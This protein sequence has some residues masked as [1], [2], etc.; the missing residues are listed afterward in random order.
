MVEQ[1]TPSPDRWLS[2]QWHSFFNA[3]VFFSRL[4]PPPGIRFTDELLNHSSRYFT[5]IGG[6]LGLLLATVVAVGEMLWSVPLAVACMMGVSLLL[7]GAFHEDGLADT[8]DGFGGGFNRAAV[9]GI[10][11]DS[12]LGT[13]GAAALFVT[14]LIRGLSWVALIEHGLPVW[15]ALPFAASWSRFWA[16]STL[17]TL[18]YARTGDDTKCKPLATRFGIGATFVALV[19]VLGLVWW[20]DPLIA[21]GLTLASVLLRGVLNRWFMRRI[22]GYTG[23]CLG[24]AQQLQEVVTLLALLALLD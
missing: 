12:R 2:V 13:Y 7:T 3:W 15:W 18:P 10:M 4:P 21:V 23:D 9:L 19:P 20:L 17:W 6:V 24:A 11:K 8:F 1:Q 5:W 16:I 14:L 22:Q